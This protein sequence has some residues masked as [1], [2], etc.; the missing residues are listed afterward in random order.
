MLA[1]ISNLFERSDWIEI[2]KGI[3][4]QAR[5]KALEF[6]NN[7]KKSDGQIQHVIEEFLFPEEL[8]AK[9]FENLSVDA[10]KY[11]ME[12]KTLQ[13]LL[14]CARVSHQWQRIAE[15][16]FSKIW[17]QL[18]GKDKPENMCW[19]QSLGL[20]YNWSNQTE[21]KTFLSTFQMTS[22]K[23]QPIDCHLTLG[24]FA[25][26]F[27][28]VEI[29]GVRVLL[30]LKCLM[31][32]AIEMTH[33]GRQVSKRLWNQ[34][35]ENAEHCLFVS[36]DQKLIATQHYDSIKDEKSQPSGWSCLFNVRRLQTGQ[37]IGKVNI[38]CPEGKKIFDSTNIQFDLKK[39]TY[40]KEGKMWT[41]YYDPSL[42]ALKEKKIKNELRQVLI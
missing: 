5:P 3:Q 32:L 24:N 16:Y 27:D 23:F 11:S 15:S 10:L 22:E 35:I 4:V 42:V 30:G 7:K 31:G 29:N 37:L 41:R 6:I 17:E 39:F 18:M 20:L 9:I 2:E 13:P 19:A 14:Q 28:K 21:K 34:T 8:I 25:L 36:T 40:Q 1:W 26:T 38:L 12:S 33:D